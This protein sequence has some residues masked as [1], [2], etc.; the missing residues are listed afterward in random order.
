M[1]WPA[2][3]S[4]PINRGWRLR[5]T[6]GT[7]VGKEFPLPTGR[8][9]LGSAPPATIV[10]PD[11]RIAPQHVS[12]D[13]RPDQVLM[14]DVSGGRGVLVNGSPL[15]SGRLTPGDAVL[16]GGFGFELANPAVPSGGGGGP[17]GPA[18]VSL[19]PAVRSAAQRFTTLSLAARV[20]ITSGAVALLLFLLVAGTRN[21][22]LVPVTL[23]AMSAVVPATLIC[24]LIERYDQT[25][26]SFRTLALTFLAGGT[27]GIIVTMVL[28]LVGG[29]LFGSLALLPVLA[30]VWEEPGKLLGT[31]LRWKHPAYDRPMD[32]LIL[33]T[34]SGLG[35]A[36]FETAGYGFTAL[37]EGDGGVGGMLN[38]LVLRG[39]TAPFGHGLWT[40]ITAAA[41]W[42]CGRD[43]RR[44]VKSKKFQTAFL[45]AVGL[46]ALWNL[47]SV[48]P[49]AGWLCVGA[50]A[51]L[52]VR[53]YRRRLAS[54]GLAP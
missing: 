10:V 27:L 11:T 29:T 36:V 33:G 16:V 35:F 26:I 28:E 53:V 17:G 9:V 41:F 46:H 25:G 39:L 47:G 38:V 49:M 1:S 13:I 43:L 45:T 30:G 40:G 34:V 51:Y 20:G 54:R 18:P 14:Q 2:Q 19:P 22:N 15:A 48:I 4:V 52:S 5:V 23:L 21:P 24:F 12:L 50:S 42:Q 32:G 3:M 44:A 7:S 31:S 37:T 8:H 6:T